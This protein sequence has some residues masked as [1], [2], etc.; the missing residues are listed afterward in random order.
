[1]ASLITAISLVLCSMII[2]LGS[3]SLL[4]A[5][6]YAYRRLELK[7]NEKVEKIVELISDLPIP[8]VAMANP[9]KF[10][11]HTTLQNMFGKISRSSFESQN[12]SPLEQNELIIKTMIES[13]EMGPSEKSLLA[14]LR[15]IG[16]HGADK[17]NFLVKYLE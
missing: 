10:N 16:S 4:E 3:P 2:A 9:K 8:E 15:K 12:L 5:Y 6:P 1:M 13:I 17:I 7:Q 11:L 14:A